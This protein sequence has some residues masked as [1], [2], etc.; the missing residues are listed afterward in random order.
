MDI[1]MK[2]KLIV[3]VLYFCTEF[4]HNKAHIEQELWKIV[5]TII[6]QQHLVKNHQ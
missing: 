1:E 3:Q 2:E 5:W 4:E 6:P